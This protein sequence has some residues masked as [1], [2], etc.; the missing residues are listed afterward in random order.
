[1]DLIYSKL[2]TITHET[3]N[4]MLR[5]I[6]PFID[7]INDVSNSTLF[8]FTSSELFITV[9]VLPFSPTVIY[10]YDRY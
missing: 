7:I 9:I 8:Y 6:L 3:H 4:H 2:E 1:M 10:R 5:S